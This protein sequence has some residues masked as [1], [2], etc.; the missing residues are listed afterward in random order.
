MEKRNLVF[1]Y[2]EQKCK[3]DGQKGTIET[4]KIEEVLPSGE[5][6]V[7][8]TDIH[9]RS[10]AANPVLNRIMSIVKKSVKPTDRRAA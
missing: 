8:H 4:F 3:I 5:K 2:N 9:F 6:T 10:K 7:V 1:S